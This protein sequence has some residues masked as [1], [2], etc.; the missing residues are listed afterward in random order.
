MY[1][2][3]LN[4]LFNFTACQ[5]IKR[6]KF[7]RSDW[8]AICGCGFYR[9]LEKDDERKMKAKYKLILIKRDSLTDQHTRTLCAM[10]AIV[11]L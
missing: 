3:T 8:N 2:Y 6:L 9:I 1:T 7:H 10:K 11:N 5:A 4:C